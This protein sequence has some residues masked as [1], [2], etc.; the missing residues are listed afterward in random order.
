MR[1]LEEKIGR[2]QRAAYQNPE[3]AKDA[4]V[5]TQL[6]HLVRGAM[7]DGVKNGNVPKDIYDNYKI[8]MKAHADFKQQHDQGAA[9]DLLKNG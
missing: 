1:V 4:M 7:D 8:A 3:L 6:K 5:L 2:L 9:A